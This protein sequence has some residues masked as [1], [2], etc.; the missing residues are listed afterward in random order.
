MSVRLTSV[1]LSAWLGAAVLFATVVA[2]AAFAVLPSRLLAGA[3]VGRVLPVVFVSGIAVAAASL[4]IDRHGGGVLPNVR[5]AAMVLIVVACAVAQFGIAPRIERVRNQIAGPIEQ[6]ARDDPHRVAFGR[7]HAISVGWL[8]LA[9]VAA[10]S[11][12]ALGSRSP[13]TGVSRANSSATVQTET[14]TSAIR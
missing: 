6:L 10:A 13:R 3:L 11:T 5:R 4:V 7:L 9:M 12:I 8:G 14:V 2:P 1:L